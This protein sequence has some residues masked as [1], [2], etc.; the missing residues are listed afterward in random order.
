MGILFHQPPKI[1]KMFPFAWN[2]RCSL[3]VH[4]IFIYLW[5]GLEEA[6]LTML[7]D[8]GSRLAGS[9]SSQFILAKE[10][11]FPN[12]LPVADLHVIMVVPAAHSAH[13]LLTKHEPSEWNATYIFSF[14]RGRSGNMSFSCNASG[15]IPLTLNLCYWGSSN[16]SFLCYFTVI[17]N[18]LLRINA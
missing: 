7:L 14:L 10:S 1:P 6:S 3:T 12:L 2:S 5:G 9:C 13:L 4:T 17:S 15:A 16:G 18:F 8:I 11:Y